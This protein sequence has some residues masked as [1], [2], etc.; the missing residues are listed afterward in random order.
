MGVARLDLCDEVTDE[1]G[2]RDARGQSDV[3]LGVA[4]QHR[5]T[6]ELRL[7]CGVRASTVTATAV[8]GGRRVSRRESVHR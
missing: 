8:R 5:N 6:Y 3:E 4:A 1:S 2:D 7:D